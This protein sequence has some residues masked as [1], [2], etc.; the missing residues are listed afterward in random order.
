MNVTLVS[1][2]TVGAGRYIL[3]KQ[4]GDNA[5]AWLAHDEIENKPVVLKFLPAELYQDPRGLEELRSQ[6]SIAQGLVHPN[7]A[8][9]YELYEA[10]GEEPFVCLEYIE[11]MNLSA[12]QNMQP[13][14]VYN[15]TFLAPLLKQI[16]A[17]L[18]FVHENRLVHGAVKPSS[19]MLDRKGQVKLLDVGIAGIL[20]NPLYGGP[21]TT[22]AGGL[23]QYLSPQQV[24]GAQP[25]GTDDI[26]S[27]GITI[28]EFLTSTPPFHSGD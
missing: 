6:V 27:L 26:Y 14:K 15:W 28:Y 7:V 13:N 12:L 9:V 20:N 16:F 23:L 19:L 10:Q 24:D 1:G 3:N 22:G 8:A 25:Q 5:L 11:G 2:Q 21:P 18:Q 4:L 17:A